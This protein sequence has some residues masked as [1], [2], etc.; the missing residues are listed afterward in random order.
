MRFGARELEDWAWKMEVW[1]WELEV[2]VWKNKNQDVGN[3]V[4]ASTLATGMQKL[5]SFFRFDWR[6]ER[7]K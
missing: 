7:G 5:I 1:A 4:D 2:W 6:S 3:A